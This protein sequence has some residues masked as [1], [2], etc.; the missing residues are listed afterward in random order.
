MKRILI[1][2]GIGALLSACGETGTDSQPAETAEPAEAVQSMDPGQA[3]EQG[4][5]LVD[6]AAEQAQALADKAAQTDTS[7]FYSGGDLNMA[8]TLEDWRNADMSQRLAS[9]A[10]LLKM[11][12]DALPAPAEAMDMAR[13]LEAGISE[14][15]DSG[16]QGRLGDV[17][18]KVF[19]AQGW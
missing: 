11:K 19:E 6:E 17:A 10:D 9:A 16:A 4:K 7:W 3:A 12:A 8:S 1:M 18:D 14:A 2:L 5:S 15:A 13:T